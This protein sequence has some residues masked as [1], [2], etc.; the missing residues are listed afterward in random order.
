M[1]TPRVSLIVVK[2]FVKEVYEMVN[3]R[4]KL[5]PK[6]AAFSIEMLVDGKGTLTARVLLNSQ[7]CFVVC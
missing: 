4:Q 5:P 3:T 1:L 6:L 2:S 7:N